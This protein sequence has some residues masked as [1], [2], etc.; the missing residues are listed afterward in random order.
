MQVAARAAGRHA[1]FHAVSEGAKRTNP[2]LGPFTAPAAPTKT[3]FLAPSAGGWGL[4]V[5]RPFVAARH[6]K[7][8]SVLFL[9]RVPFGHWLREE[10][11]TNV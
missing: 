10:L 1:Q 5:V 9:P 7:A 8:P 6:S 3:V 11:G 2:P 4:G